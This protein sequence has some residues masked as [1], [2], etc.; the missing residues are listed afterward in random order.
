MNHEYCQR[1]VNIC[2]TLHKLLCDYSSVWAQ[3]L[4]FNVWKFFNISFHKKSI[5]SDELDWLIQ[6][7]FSIMHFNYGCREKSMKYFSR[8]QIALFQ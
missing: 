3:V 4:Q 2:E 5:V 1:T 7:L 8:V 6:I